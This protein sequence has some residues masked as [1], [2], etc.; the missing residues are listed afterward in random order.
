[1]SEKKLYKCIGIMGAMFGHKFIK[2]AGGY[3]FSSNY[4]YRCGMPKGGMTDD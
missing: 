1:M 4:C 3:S 2:L